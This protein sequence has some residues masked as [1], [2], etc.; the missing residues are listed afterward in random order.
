VILGSASP[1][2]SYNICDAPQTTLTGSVTG[3]SAAAWGGVF[4]QLCEDIGA[5]GNDNLQ[6][7]DLFAFEEQIDVPLLQDLAIDEPSASVIPTGTTVSSYYVAF[8]PSSS[9]QLIGTVTFPGTILGVMTAEPSLTAS[10]F[11]GNP[12]ASYLNPSLR[13][14]EG[15]V[16]IVSTAGNTLTVDLSASSPG[17]YARV[18]VASPQPVPAA[19]PVVLL[20]LTGSLALLGGAAARR[21]R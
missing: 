20:V 21:C 13:G 12:T 17:D 16:D 9:K 11:L 7:N 15:G 2:L 8:D 5:V 1:S 14:L 19:S 4:V 3:G 10:D 6:A 18:M